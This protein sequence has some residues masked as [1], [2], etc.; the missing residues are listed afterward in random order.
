MN[1]N[2]D[3]EWFGAHLASTY[4]ETTGQVKSSHTHWDPPAKWRRIHKLASTSHLKHIWVLVSGS[5]KH[6]SICWW[7]GLSVNR[8]GML[9]SFT[10]KSID[11]LSP[12]GRQCVWSKEQYLRII[13]M[14]LVMF[15]EESV[16]S[17]PTVVLSFSQMSRCPR[18]RRPRQ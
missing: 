4:A 3:C 5:W 18:K 10:R 14:R 9:S 12:S 6:A 13:C 2:E 1:S 17:R 15:E 8:E 11:V 16:Y 7:K